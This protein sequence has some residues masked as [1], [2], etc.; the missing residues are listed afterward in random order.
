MKTNGLSQSARR[1]YQA[2]VTEV[3]VL[4]VEKGFCASPA[5]VG[6]SDD[7]ERIGEGDPIW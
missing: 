5:I 4:V 6:G 1:S 2:P 7:N 3:V